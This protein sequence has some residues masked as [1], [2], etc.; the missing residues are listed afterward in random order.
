MF[1]RAAGEL[2]L[3]V[4][5]L[6]HLVMWAWKGTTV[7]GIVLRLNIVRLNG[8]PINFAVALVR[9]LS[10]FFSTLLFCLGFFWAGW[11]RDRQSWHDIIAGTV[12]VRLPPGA[13]LV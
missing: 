6:Y 4:W 10:A 8:E 12:I 11:S 1:G 3:P 9:C 5:I 13:R 2:F 7:G